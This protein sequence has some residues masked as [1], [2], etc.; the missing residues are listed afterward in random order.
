MCAWAPSAETNVDLGDELLLSLYR[1]ASELNPADYVQ[2]VFGMLQSLVSFDSAG[3]SRL[4]TLSGK[5][6]IMGADL[7]RE[8]PA[9]LGE[10]QSV[11]HFDPVLARGLSQAGRAIA[12]HAPTIATSMRNAGFEHYLQ[13]NTHHQNGMVILTP[14]NGEWDAFGFYRS[15]ADQQFSRRDMQLI[16]MLTPHVLQANRINLRLARVIEA[17]SAT[18]SALVHV[19]GQL[20]H[21]APGV[22]AL[23]RLEWPDWG[24]H[25]LPPELMAALRA[26]PSRRFTGKRIGATADNWGDLI[27]L[28]VK[29]LS[30]MGNLSPREALAARLYGSGL[31][32][33]EI[34]RRMDVA[35]NT[36]RNFVQNVYR[37][38][39]VNDKAALA[40]LLASA[41]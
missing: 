39:N 23:L 24:G 21:A 14:A 38:L 33:K 36:V 18:A 29:P 34:A 2:W 10:W 40:V 35:P 20:H 17:A 15:A 8:N 31:S 5:T 12:F 6:L 27:A 3:R 16:E 19:N 25:M 4:D 1:T 9:M 7:Y 41:P 13:S 26:S 22:A 32:T 37:K 28:H 11:N 30:S